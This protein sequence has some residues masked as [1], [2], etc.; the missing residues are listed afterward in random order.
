MFSLA[1]S[2]SG[3]VQIAMTVGCVKDEERFGGRVEAHCLDNGTYYVE[4]C[5]PR[6]SGS[7]S[8]FLS[9]AQWRQIYTAHRNFDAGRVQHFAG[10]FEQLAKDSGGSSNA[11]DAQRIADAWFKRDVALGEVCHVHTPRATT[12]TSLVLWR[13]W[14]FAGPSRQVLS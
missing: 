14:S 8:V 13:C 1:L 12:R 6:L 10:K 2:L 5:G 4:A 3:V 11:F 9:D 7:T